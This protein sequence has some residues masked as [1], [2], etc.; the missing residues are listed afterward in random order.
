MFTVFVLPA[1]AATPSIE[2][3][4]AKPTDE[5]R[6][7]ARWRGVAVEVRSPSGEAVDSPAVAGNDFQIVLPPALFASK[8][9]EVVIEWVD[10]WR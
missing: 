10:Y 4:T 2:A 3:S 9:G 6:L 8:P 1:G 7:S 5:I